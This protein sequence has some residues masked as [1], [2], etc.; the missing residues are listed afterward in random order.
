[1]SPVHMLNVTAPRLWKVRLVKASCGGASR[2][3]RQEKASWPV[4][5]SSLVAAGDG[6]NGQDGKQQE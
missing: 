3:Q 1:M 6:S 4:L 2:P 5:F